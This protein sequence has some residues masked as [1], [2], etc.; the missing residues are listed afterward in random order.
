MKIEYKVEKSN[1]LILFWGKVEAEIEF[2]LPHQASAEKLRLEK[3][4]DNASI[5]EAMNFEENSKL[6]GINPE[7]GVLKVISYSKDPTTHH[8]QRVE[9]WER[10]TKNGSV[11]Y[12]AV[13]EFENSELW[14]FAEYLSEEH[15]L[16]NHGIIEFPSKEEALEFCKSKN[17][18][19]FVP[20]SNFGVYGLDSTKKIKGVK[21]EFS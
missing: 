5:L 6:Y 12:A 17:R 7:S 4:L 16:Q 15:I 1:L 10:A 20:I 9:E 13:K 11:V 18:N 19:G 21:I 8:N 14:A 3:A 2:R